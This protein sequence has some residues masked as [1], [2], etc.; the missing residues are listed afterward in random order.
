[1]TSRQP[2]RRLIHKDR[3][4]YIFGALKTQNYHDPAARGPGSHMFVLLSVPSHFSSL[5]HEKGVQGLTV[6]IYL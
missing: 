2:D 3:F 1:M 5:Y 4:G 6:A